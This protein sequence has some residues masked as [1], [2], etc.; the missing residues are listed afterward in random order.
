M[1]ILLASIQL[2]WPLDS[3]GRVAV[4]SSLSCLCKD[5]RFTLVC[6]VWEQEDLSDAEAL[7]ARLP[8]IKVRAVYCRPLEP[9]DSTK[10]EHK[11]EGDVMGRSLSWIAWRYWSWRFPPPEVIP[12]P[13]EPPPPPEVPYYPFAP[14]PEPFIEALVDELSQGVDLVQAEFTEMLSLGAWL[15]QSI[16]KIF[17]H[18]QPHF[19]YV[20]RF[21]GVRKRS[22][23]S[24]YLENVMRIQEQAYLEKFDSVVVF[25]EDDKRALTELLDDEKVYVSSFPI[26]CKPETVAER[27]EP[28]F[29]FVGAEEHFPNHDALQWLTTEIWPE[30]LMQAPGCTLKVIGRWSED[31]IARFSRPGIEF[32]GFVPD[33]E[34]AVK[35]SVLLVPLRIGS[36]IR[37]KLLNAMS[38]GIPA[39]STSIGCEGIPV[40][41]GVEILIRDAAQEFA[42][43]AA[44]LLINLEARARL[45][46]AGRDLLVRNYSPERFRQRRNDIYR[47]V[48][49]RAA[50]LNKLKQGA[51]GHD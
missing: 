13:K 42:S 26:A 43:A 11:V 30:I 8:E 4:Y 17:V 15:P 1:N 38:Q 9:T 51:Q 5:H 27:F 39:V 37:V 12:K 47:I 25:S 14:Q 10:D 31:S 16:P 20:N 29:T 21:S 23:Y 2:P 49:E 44:E 46:R 50:G 41:D 45:S 35:G 33:L 40:R 48:C 7:Q 19:V 24:E 28:H 34:E 36:G 32:A 6:P 18:H 22:G 3:G